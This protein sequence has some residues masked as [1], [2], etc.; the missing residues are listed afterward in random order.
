MKRE[1]LFRGKRTD[2]SGWIFGDVI[3]W[4]R[5]GKCAILPQEGDQWHTPIE[6]EVIP[7]TVGQFTGLTDKKGTKIFE[8]DT[9]D[10]GEYVAFEN[11]I[12]GTTYP[13]NSQGINRLSQKRCEHII[14][15]GNVHEKI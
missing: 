9:T 11:G 14:I 3:Q 8:G 13:G 6:F 4:K 1:I 2:G 5:L 10:A 15:T 12:F 7:E